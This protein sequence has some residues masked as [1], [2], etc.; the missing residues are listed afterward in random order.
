MA[1]SFHGFR[2]TVVTLYTSVAIGGIKQMHSAAQKQTLTIA[3][4]LRPSLAPE[5]SKQAAK[6]EEEPTR[7]L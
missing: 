4:L 7:R 6:E 5:G 2:H 3:A 1:W